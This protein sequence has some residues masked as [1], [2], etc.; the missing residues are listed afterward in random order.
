MQ[1]YTCT[2]TEKLMDRLLSYGYEAIQLSEGVLGLVDYVFLS[3]DP[4]KYNFLIR[5]RYLNAWSS[6]Q[7]IRRFTNISKNLQLEIDKACA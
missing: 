6:G 1:I 3:N 4:H 5:E 7:T 2:A